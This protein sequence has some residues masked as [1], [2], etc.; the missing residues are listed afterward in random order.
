VPAATAK[1]LGEIPLLS[2]LDA[3]E[4]TALAAGA[5]VVEFAAGDEL[6]AQGDMPDGAYFVRSGAVEVVTKLPGGGETPVADLGP[7]S[8]VGE[9]GLIH[10]SRRT[11]S[12]RAT[13]P[14]SALFIDRRFFRAAC[15]QL[16]PGAL[17]ASRRIALIL[18]GRLRILNER[19]VGL[20]APDAPAPHPAPAESLDDLRGGDAPFE[21][22]DFLPLLACFKHFRPDA[23]D[24]LV[25]RTSPLVAPPGRLLFAEGD[26]PRSCLI[27]V[28]GALELSAR[29]GDR[30]HQLSILGPGEMCSVAP[31]ID[32][33]AQPLDYGVRESA[34]L[35]ELPRARF[36]EI[37]EAD[38]PLSL[39]LLNA[40]N[41][42]LTN[43]LR[44][45]D[46]TLTRLV[47]LARIHAQFAG[48]PHK[49]V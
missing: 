30:K 33:L 2:D 44:R 32:G 15:E 48:A 34:L 36:M 28:R 4:L 38:T 24:D 10:S 22:R 6:I 18:S 29:R 23:I 47:G 27:V 1:L 16:E 45:A 41:E 9:L 26:A 40:V 3:D 49:T 13:E 17:K 42:N 35:L 43:H 14:V 25:A 7:G 37:Y 12:V 11:A 31:L 8:T 19:L 20:M 46:N 21:Y 5:R 39:A